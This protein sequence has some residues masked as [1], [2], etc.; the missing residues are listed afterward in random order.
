M[1]LL[2]IFNQFFRGFSKFPENQTFLETNFEIQS[3]HKPL[4]ESCEVPQKIGLDRFTRSD[5]YWI[6]TD[7]QSIN[8]LP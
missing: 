8:I 5:V 1:M 3:V 4:L 6:H 2:L 7:K